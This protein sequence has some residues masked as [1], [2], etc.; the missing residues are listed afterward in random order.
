M[1]KIEFTEPQTAEWTQ[2]VSD[3]RQR[4]VTHN[5]AIVAGQPV[6]ADSSLYGR[7]KRT[8]FTDVDGAFHGKCA[9]C[10]ASIRSSQHGDIEH[11]RPKGAVVD[12][13]TNRA[14]KLAATGDPHPGYYWLAYNWENLLP[15]CVL[16]N[17]PSTEPGEQRI[18]KR[19][20]FP[21]ADE[22]KRAQKPGDEAHEKPLFIHPVKEDPGKELDIDATGVLFARDGSAR[23]EA[24]IRILGLNLRELRTERKRVYDDTKKLFKVYFYNKLNAPGSQET[25]EEEERL[26]QIE[27]GSEPFTIAARRAIADAKR[28]LRVL[29]DAL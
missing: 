9:F 1:I 26:R 4:Q 10:E 15:S 16:C 28:E 11:F 5:A 14:I 18:G 20:Y 17:Q 2:W 12:E 7:L 22:T 27:T 25:I 6:S 3:C 19:N 8:V 24:C 13:A 21:L 23:G 29:I